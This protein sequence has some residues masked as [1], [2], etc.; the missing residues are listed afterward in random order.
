MPGFVNRSY[1][2]GHVL[3]MLQRNILWF[4]GIRPVRSTAHGMVEGVSAT[5]RHKWLT[6]VEGMGRKTR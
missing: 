6:A 3:K 5:K 1:F 2:G 4:V